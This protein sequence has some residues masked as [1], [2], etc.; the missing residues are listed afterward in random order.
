MA[1]GSIVGVLGFA[2]AAYHAIQ[3]AKCAEFHPAGLYPSNFEEDIRF[4][5]GRPQI[6]GE[7]LADLEVRLAFNSKVLIDRSNIIDLAMKRLWTTP[8]YA[9][10]SVV[11]A[12]LAQQTIPTS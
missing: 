5:K 7:V 10:L 1:V 11:L 3:S 4:K 8:L 12:W 9:L 2:R 6:E